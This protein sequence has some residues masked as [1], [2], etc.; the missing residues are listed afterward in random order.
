MTVIIDDQRI[1]T[2]AFE[3]ICWMDDQHV[4]RAT[5]G[6]KRTKDTVVAVVLHTVHGKP[7]KLVR[8]T[9]P[10]KR[11]ETYA[12]YQTATE[13][14]VSWHFTVD[15][16][17]TVVQSAD[18]ARW[19]C[20]HAGKV[21]AWT[22]GIELVQDND[23]T[24]YSATLDAAVKLVELLCEK[25]GVERRLPVDAAG[26]PS[27]G[28]IRALTGE[29]GPWSGVFGHRNQTHNRGRG[30]P[31][32]QVFS[33]LLE[34][35]FTGVVLDDAPSVAPAAAPT[36]PPSAPS[37]TPPVA[38]KPA[39]T[40]EAAKPPPA[41]LSWLDSRVEIDARKDCPR[42]PASFVARHRAA[43]RELGVDD[44]HAAT[45]IAHASVESDWG[46]R[47]FGFNTGGVKATKADAVAYER[48]HDGPMPWW[49][50]KGHVKS[51]DAV[52]A[53]YRGFDSVKDFWAFWLRRFVPKEG[54]ER[55][56]ET[57][58]LF[59]DDKAPLTAWFIEML[60]AG[61]RGVVRERELKALLAAGKDGTSHP[62]VLAHEARVREVRKWFGNG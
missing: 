17:G 4:P 2:P 52:W 58:R 24:L 62:S 41:P 42:D 9:K 23:G 61:Y 50:S 31:G 30:D 12:H 44:A 21:N 49:R 45:V 37:A 29:R 16:D 27:R 3:S 60:R 57:G 40:A 53:Y 7:G 18:P 46:R 43:L 1:D 15:T 36:K 33:A 35:G 39:S 55:Y 54:G 8:G 38:P 26:A 11:A 19:L 5:D 25:L 20:W 34:A 10:S 22:V 59:W 48:T 56:R 32:D 13:R 47:E 14:E 28:V 51:G 6:R